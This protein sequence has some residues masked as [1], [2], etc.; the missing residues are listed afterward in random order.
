VL[1]QAQAPACG[2]LQHP[3]CCKGWLQCVDQGDPR[4]VGMQAVRQ[5]SLF[6]YGGAAMALKAQVRCFVARK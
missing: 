6:D 3:S 4:I 1:L 5:L 2:V